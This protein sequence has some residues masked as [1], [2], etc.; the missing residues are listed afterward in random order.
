M[1]SIH[2]TR[3]RLKTAVLGL[4]GS[5]NIE[6]IKGL[7]GLE[8]I[9]CGIQSESWQIIDQEKFE[10]YLHHFETKFK[11]IGWQP[12]DPISVRFP[13]A[14]NQIRPIEV[15]TLEDSL[16]YDIICQ[17]LLEEHQVKLRS[18]RANHSSIPSPYIALLEHIDQE[19]RY[20]LEEKIEYIKSKD[21]FKKLENDEKIGIKEYFDIELT[22]G[23]K[24]EE[25]KNQIRRTRFIP[26]YPQWHRF[27]SVDLR[28]DEDFSADFNVLMNKEK[29]NYHSEYLLQFDMKKCFENIKHDQLLEILKNEFKIDAHLYEMIELFLYQWQGSGASENLNQG[30]SIP[31][32]YPC[33]HVLANMYFYHLDQ[34][35]EAFTKRN[36]MIY[37][38]YVD[39]IKIYFDTKSRVY[40]EFYFK[41]LPKTI[42][43]NI[44]QMDIPDQSKRKLT[45]MKMDILDEI[46]DELA[47]L[48]LTLNM[49]KFKAYDSCQ[50]SNP[51]RNIFHELKELLKD[52]NS[53]ISIKKYIKSHIHQ[54]HHLAYL[55]AYHRQ[56]PLYEIGTALTSKNAPF[57]K[58][59]DT[60]LA[61][62]RKT[63][64]LMR[65]R[66]MIKFKDT[67]L[68]LTI[69]KDPALFL[70]QYLNHPLKDM[71]IEYLKKDLFLKHYLLLNFTEADIDRIYR[72]H[73][74]KS[75]Y[76]LITCEKVI[77]QGK[78]QY[79]DH[80][81][82]KYHQIKSLYIAQR[83]SL[84]LM[85]KK[86][87]EKIDQYLWLYRF[88]PFR[89]QDMLELLIEFERKKDLYPVLIT[90]VLELMRFYPREIAK[91]IE[92]IF[93]LQTIKAKSILYIHEKH[94]SEEILLVSTRN[95]ELIDEILN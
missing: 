16:V 50:T 18:I 73:L 85:S 87:I 34:K 46:Q 52:K 54:I 29:I 19:S 71:S 75:A 92:L 89:T 41:S 28:F 55:Y 51:F 68:L 48:G 44:N 38:R 80:Y 47:T 69:L 57:E 79:L 12:S 39:D 56:L 91:D 59:V 78:S 4:L 64:A 36:H 14:S 9:G 5:K 33:S 83:Q 31:Q 3:S 70:F 6:A 26:Y 93:K 84:L 17:V 74:F 40:S 95:I 88:M 49:D 1:H 94:I 61:F 20:S 27:S 24:L 72:A 8:D 30:K 13:K 53:S 23:Y 37:L 35:L 66:L 42:D 7:M 45:K 67:D 15:L 82:I 60:A 22:E 90:K 21:E 65:N 2:F 63:H 76:E 81:F 43:H 58:K 25:V 86:F 32:L 10:S 77:K 62:R 11:T